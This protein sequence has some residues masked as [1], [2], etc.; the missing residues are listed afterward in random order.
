MAKAA[1]HTTSLC[2]WVSLGVTLLVL[3]ASPSSWAH[4]QPGQE[5]RVVLAAPDASKFP[6]IQFQ[7]EAY[8]AEGAF[9]DTLQAED[10]AILEDEKELSPAGLQ[11]LQPGLQFIVAVNAAPIMENH[12]NGVSRYE[13]AQATLSTWS[14]AQPFSTPDTFSLATNTGI[15]A[16]QLSD[17]TEWT[18]AILSYQ[19][20]LLKARPNLNS[21]TQ[22]IDLAGDGGPERKRIL[23]Y[24]TPTLAPAL[25]DNLPAQTQRAVQLGLRVFVWLVA[26]P[27]A[28]NDLKQQPLR[29]LAGQTGGALFL[30]T[31]RE[32]L[33]DPETLLKPQ[34]SLY[35]AQY[36][37]AVQTSGEH[38]LAIRLRAPGGAIRSEVQA[39]SI[40]VQPP[41]PLF[42]T[43]P[44]QVERGWVKG[45]N[46]FETTLQPESIALQTLVEFPDGHPR[47]LRY[48]RLY[49]DG[50]MVAENQA[51]PFNAFRWDLRQYTTSQRH[52][53]QIQ[54]EDIL[55]LSKRS[56]EIPVDFVVAEPEQRPLGNILS[57][58]RFYLGLA[59]LASALLAALGVLLWRRNQQPA[60]YQDP[61][62]QPVNIRQERSLSPRRAAAEPGSQPVTTAP[63]NQGAADRPS[64]PH[65]RVGQ[66]APARLVPLGSDAP[67][68][69]IALTYQEMTFGSDPQLSVHVL[70]DPSVSPLHARLR[71]TPEGGF[72]LADAG[73]VAGTWVNYAPVSK[74]GT[75][76]EHGDLVNFGRS[77]FRFEL[78]NPPA[79]RQIQVTVE[80]EQP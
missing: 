26:P 38:N 70:T 30:F 14:K 64:W 71:Q 53:I 19:P 45:S 72:I 80:K 56:A 57:D 60:S 32:Q 46:S 36:T 33:P 15:Q 63:A 25:L 23:L 55:G 8:D 58:Q 54:A 4:A 1:R 43:P 18:N 11:K 78:A 51:E 44:A 68:S 73:S 41:N 29:D 39:F 75:G 74:Q 34:R 42:V 12:F 76:L 22:A 52:L 69:S 27:A 47:P 37:S 2:L 48:T 67:A 13:A 40:Q 6:T 7:F 10:V 50:Q 65:I 31:G 3:L 66:L 61:V 9:I 5:Q 62:T 79:S 77:R 49:V 16:S 21:L 59:L 35:R 24:I 17:P 28:A 20:D